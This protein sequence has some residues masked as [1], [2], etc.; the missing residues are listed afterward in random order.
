MLVRLNQWFES[1]SIFAAK[2]PTIRE[3][4]LKIVAKC[5]VMCGANPH[6]YNFYRTTHDR[7]CNDIE[8]RKLN[9]RLEDLVNAVSQAP[10][11]AFWK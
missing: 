2:E 10:L 11:I 6:P 5:L 8:C 1:T 9:Q 7:F 4:D 3:R